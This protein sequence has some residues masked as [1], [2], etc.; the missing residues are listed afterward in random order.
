M[1]KS[2]KKLKNGLFLSFKGGFPDAIKLCASQ[3]IINWHGFFPSLLH[4][5]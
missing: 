2:A 4:L 5:G 1:K 3:K